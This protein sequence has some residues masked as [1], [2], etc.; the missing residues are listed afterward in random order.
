[1]VRNQPEDNLRRF[2][3]KRLVAVVVKVVAAKVTVERCSD[4]D[5]QVILVPVL[6]AVNDHGD[7]LGKVGQALV[8]DGKEPRDGEVLSR[9][10]VSA[11]RNRNTLAV[12]S[13]D[14][15]DQGRVGELAVRAEDLDQVSHRLGMNRHGLSHLVHL[16]NSLRL[17]LVS[18]HACLKGTCVKE[19]V[20]RHESTSYVRDRSPNVLPTTFLRG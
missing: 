3:R 6:A 13:V 16:S 18:T 8:T 9:D 15:I 11:G 5:V 17:C 12:L 2:L 20:H 4:L 10:G 7:K 1:M 14:R 19:L